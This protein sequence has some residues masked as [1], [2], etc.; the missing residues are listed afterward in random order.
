MHLC[1]TKHQ[2]SMRKNTPARCGE[3]GG[4]TGPFT[5][6][7]NASTAS[8]HFVCS[9]CSAESSAS[10]ITDLAE[11][12]EQLLEMEENLVKMEPLLKNAPKHDDLPEGLAQFAQTPLSMYNSMQMYVAALKTRRVEILSSSRSTEKIQYELDQMLSEE[13]YEAAI[14]LKKEL[15]QVKAN[16]PKKKPKK[17]GKSKIL[18]QKTDESAGK[19]V[20][21]KTNHPKAP[22]LFY[23]V[24]F[25]NIHEMCVS[26][27]GQ[28]IPSIV[29][30]IKTADYMIEQMKRFSKFSDGLSSLGLLMQMRDDPNAD[31]EAFKNS[32]KSKSSNHQFNENFIEALQSQKEYL[33]LVKEDPNDIDELV[34]L[35]K[36]FEQLPE[37]E[38]DLIDML[39]KAMMEVF[40][41]MPDKKKKKKSEPKKKK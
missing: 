27:I 3:C 12:D 29:R 15:E 11:L 19:C 8:T 16:P 33:E 36:M 13:N 24:D 31:F 18:F 20:S 26:C 21:C 5:T 6:F 34:N 35:Q 23:E 37:K 39:S 4:S 38:R 2:H 9:R 40:G 30:T 25:P 22:G 1:P 7:V 10:E 41:E 17:E 28:Q 14:L 32:P